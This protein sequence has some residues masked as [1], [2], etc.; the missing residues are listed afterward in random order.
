MTVI[1]SLMICGWHIITRGE[2]IVTP[3]DKWKRDGM[4]FRSWE[5]F[6]ERCVGK[7]IVYYEGEQLEKKFSL[8]GKVRPDISIKMRVDETM[9]CL[10]VK[11]GEEVSERDIDSMKDQ[12]MC[13]IVDSEDR[14]VHLF[15]I[16]P[17][18]RFPEWVRKPISACPT[19]MASIYGTLFYWFVVSQ[20]RDIFSW[21]TQENFAKFGFWGIFCVILSCSNKYIAQKMKL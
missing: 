17:I 1:A 7:K 13:E 11:W 9:S 16:E 5:L 10:R 20:A 15:Q 3:D 6:W 12:L 21:S 14:T 8:L 18:Y 2:Y 4:I 19:C